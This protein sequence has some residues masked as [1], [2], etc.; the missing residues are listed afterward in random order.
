[1]RSRKVGQLLRNGSRKVKHLAIFMAS[2]QAEMNKIIP[3]HEMF[4]WIIQF[5]FN[6]K[7]FN[8][9]HRL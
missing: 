5:D 7:L 3:I 1:M 6:E 4:T 8:D 2:V 9:Y